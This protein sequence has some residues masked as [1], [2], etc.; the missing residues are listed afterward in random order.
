MMG[1]E[2]T[3]VDHYESLMQRLWTIPTANVIQTKDV[4]G[5]G[6]YGPI[7]KGS[8]QKGDTKIEAALHAIEGD[9]ALLIKS[10]FNVI[11]SSFYENDWN[12][13][14]SFLNLIFS[15]DFTLTFWI[16]ISHILKDNSMPSGTKQSM[17]KD[18]GQLVKV[19]QHANIAGIIGV[20]EE[21]GK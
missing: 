13:T 16:N 4:L 20:C 19:G 18:L 5:T 12:G 1:I 15:I 14:D 9:I 8:V 17:L 7:F 6:H 11:N 21:P 10:Y 3:P 2:E